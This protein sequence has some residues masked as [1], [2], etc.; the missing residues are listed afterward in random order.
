[1]S[2]DYNALCFQCKEYMHV[3]QIMG[4]KPSL[5]YGAGEHPD[6]YIE[7]TREIAKFLFDHVEHG[8]VLIV[9]SHD[10]P[11]TFRNADL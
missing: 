8:A 4:G 6:A 11:S 9:V 10:T 3:G 2:T 7:E 1:M 5:S